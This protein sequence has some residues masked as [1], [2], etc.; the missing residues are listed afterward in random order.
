MFPKVSLAVHVTVV[1][2]VEKESGASFEK[3]N[4]QL[5][6]ITGFPN[7]IVHEFD[8]KSGGAEIFGG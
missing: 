1:V 2:P 6:V 4:E 3:V 8:T 7:T 5:S